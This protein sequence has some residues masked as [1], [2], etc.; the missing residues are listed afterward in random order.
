MAQI[1]YPDGTSKEMRPGNG[2]YFSLEEKQKIVGGLIEIAD[3]IHPE[4]VLIINEEGKLENLPFN[5]QATLLYK[6]HIHEGKVWDVL[7]GTVLYGDW[8]EMF[9]EDWEERYGEKGD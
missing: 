3:C 6:W 5:P 2:K 1:I 8:S 4:K 9:E 7:V